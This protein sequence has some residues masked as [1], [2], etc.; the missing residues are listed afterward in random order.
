VYG[1]LLGAQEGDPVDDVGACCSEECIARYQE[2]KKMI[3][4]MMLER[5]P[6]DPRDPLKTKIPIAT[7]I[8]LVVWVIVF[9]TLGHLDLL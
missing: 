6:E 3:Q 4:L 9:T 2:L 8:A 7:I 5:M 1:P